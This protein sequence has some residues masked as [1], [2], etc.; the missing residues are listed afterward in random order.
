MKLNKTK[1]DENYLASDIVSFALTYFLNPPH[2]SLKYAIQLFLINIAQNLLQALKKLI[3]VSHLNPFKFLFYCRKQVEV[4]GTN[5][6][7]RVGVPCSACHALQANLL[8][9]D[10]Y[11]LNNY[12]DESQ[13]F[14]DAALFFEYKSFIQME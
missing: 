8:K 7:N 3:I 12:R 2:P 4:I 6:T 5:Q 13:V 10:L 9:P 1:I 11:E 14:S